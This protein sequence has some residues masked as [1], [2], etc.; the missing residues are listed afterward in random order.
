MDVTMI[1]PMGVRDPNAKRVCDINKIRGRIFSHIDEFTEQ[2]SSFTEYGLNEEADCIKKIISDLWKHGEM[3][4]ELLRKNNPEI[5]EAQ[6]LWRWTEDK[7][8][9]KKN[10]CPECWEEFEG[11]TCPECGYVLDSNKEKDA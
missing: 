4:N 2:V 6:D 8:E 3:L 9:I 1:N 10:V 5:K 7:W 11:D